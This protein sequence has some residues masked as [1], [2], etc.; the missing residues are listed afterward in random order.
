M[1]INFR[2][3]KKSLEARI[4]IHNKYGTKNIDSWMLDLLDLRKGIKVLD[5]GCG[6][7]K[8][9]FIIE[10]FLDKECNI[11]GG[12]ESEILIE[13]AIKENTSRNGKVTFIK[14][15][16]DEVMPF[17][18]K[19]FDLVTSCFAIYYADDIKFTIKE[20]FR[21]LRNGGVLFLSGP[22]PN[23]KLEFNRIIEIAASAKVPPLTGSSRFTTEILNAVVDE[24]EIIKLEVFKNRVV[25]PSA[26]PFVT[27]AESILSEKRNV[28]AAL[29]ENNEFNEVIK[30]V[31]ILAEKEI[32]EKGEIVMTKVVGG[33]IATKNGLY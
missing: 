24:F 12:D 29:F 18:N 16:F 5:L 15:D 19:S 32:M 28:Y 30:K 1:A 10:D 8:Q 27:Y 23:N 22:M 33:I 21:V 11:I 26:E 25:F 14:S 9:S 4:D 13:K 31:E 6:T 7:G 20:I 3:T 2:E 17:E